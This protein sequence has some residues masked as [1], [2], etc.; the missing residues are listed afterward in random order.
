MPENNVGL[1]TFLSEVEQPEE[2][3]FQEEKTRK[4]IFK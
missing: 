4:S 2:K 1:G 3:N